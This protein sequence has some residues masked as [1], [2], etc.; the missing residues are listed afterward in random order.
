MV[1]R[2][3]NV[4]L[5]YALALDDLQNGDERN[6]IL[7][8]GDIAIRDKDGFYYIVGRIS[9]FLKLYGTRVGLDE[10]EQLISEN[11]ESEAM[12]TGNDEKMKIYV[13]NSAILEAVLSFVI[14]K[15]GLYHQAFE[16][17]YIPAIPRNDVGK[18]I[19]NFEQ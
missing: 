3:K 1:Y 9:R 17:L 11:F 16:V 12:C 2:G 10:M 7:N 6:G 19:Y 13:T 18:I 14:L 8:T 4:T 15:T 5:G